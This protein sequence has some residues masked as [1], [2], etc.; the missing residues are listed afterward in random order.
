MLLLSFFTKGL[1]GGLA[2]AP[3]F[4]VGDATFPA[5]AA[6]VGTVLRCGVAPVEEKQDGR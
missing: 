2:R 4:G 6:L 5:W 3:V 1:T